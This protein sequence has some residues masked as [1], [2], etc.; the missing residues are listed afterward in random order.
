MMRRNYSETVLLLNG[1]CRIFIQLLSRGVAGSP[2]FRRHLRHNRECCSY[3]TLRARLH[4]SRRSAS[5]T[6]NG[7]DRSRCVENR[8]AIGRNAERFHP[9]LVQYERVRREFLWLRR[10]DIARCLRRDR[11]RGVLTLHG[12]GIRG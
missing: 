3:S 10:F 9:P 6:H 2:N 12:D 7:D 5:S 1:W 4:P 8:A 11:W